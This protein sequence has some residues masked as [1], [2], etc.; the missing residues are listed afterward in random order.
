MTDSGP[1]SDATTPAEARL[2]E[3]LAVLREQPPTPAPTLTPTIVRTARWQRVVRV[4]LRAMGAMTL[5]LV[6]GLG[7]VTRRRTERRTG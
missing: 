3:H 4:P 2:V 7:L 5:A 1:A 6:E